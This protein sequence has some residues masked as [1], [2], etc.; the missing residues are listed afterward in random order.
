M[1]LK[2]YGTTCS[3]NDKTL[4]ITATSFVAKKALSAEQ[5]II[6]LD[7]ITYLDFRKGNVFINGRIIIGEPEGKTYIAIL[8][9]N[10]YILQAN[11]FYNALQNAVSPIGKLTKVE[12]KELRNDKIASMKKEAAVKKRSLRIVD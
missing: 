2:A 9:L 11:E 10:K 4:T 3:L 5:R 6:N 7:N 8:P 1:E 12:P